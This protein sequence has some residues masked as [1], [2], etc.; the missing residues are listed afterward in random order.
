MGRRM[1]RIKLTGGSAWGSI[2]FA[3]ILVAL[4]LVPSALATQTKNTDEGVPAF[5]HVFVIIGENAELGNVNKSNSPYLFGHIKPRSAWHTNYFSLAHNSLANYIGMTSGQFIPCDQNDDPPSTCHQEVPNLFNQMDSAGVSWKSWMES[6]PK[7]CDLTPETG[8]LKDSNTYRT[9]HNPAIYYADIEGAGGVWSAKNKSAECPAN[10][11][12]AGTTASN[13]MSYF[14]EAVTAGHVPRFNFIVP[15]QC[16]D[17][18]DNCKPSGNPL[19][20]FDDF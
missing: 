11:V 17:A 9:K 4:A 13:D 8:T 14:N 12:P 15:N 7:P 6:M 1:R 2:A 10:D 20:Q 16:E 5:G 3:A 18:H 19:T